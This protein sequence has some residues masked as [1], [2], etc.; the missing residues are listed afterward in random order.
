[1]RVGEF[2]RIFGSGQAVVKLKFRERIS[3]HEEL[4]KLQYSLFVSHY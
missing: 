2:H 1:M 3:A 4:D